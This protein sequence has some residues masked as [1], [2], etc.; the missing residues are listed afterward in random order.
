MPGPNLRKG[1]I[2]APYLA[3]PSTNAFIDP[4]YFACGLECRQ[5]TLSPLRPRHGSAGGI[6]AFAHGVPADVVAQERSNLRANGFRIA[7]RNQNATP[8]IQ[9]LPGVPVGGRDDGLSQS[10]A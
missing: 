10:K 6:G 9:Q 1:V 2:L 7:E 8:V 5:I 3:V 4:A